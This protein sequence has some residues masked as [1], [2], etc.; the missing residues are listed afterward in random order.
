MI[1]HWERLKPVLQRSQQ[2]LSVLRGGISEVLEH[3]TVHR[4]GQKEKLPTP[5]EKFLMQRVTVKLEKK[6]G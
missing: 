1:S 4:K 3:Y 6:I 2:I 5:G